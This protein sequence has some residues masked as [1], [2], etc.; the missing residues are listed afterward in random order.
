[1]NDNISININFV[2]LWTGHK[3][4]EGHWSLCKMAFCACTAFIFV[5]WGYFK[6]G[7]VH[8]YVLYNFLYPHINKQQKL[9]LELHVCYNYLTIFQRLL[10]H[11][12][13]PYQLLQFK[14]D[15][16]LRQIKCRLRIS[17]SFIVFQCFV[18]CK[19]ATWH[20]SISV[21]EIF[22]CE[23]TSWVYHEKC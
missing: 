19:S 4:L 21:N 5:T 15:G 1:V 20:E 6:W 7:S 23:C 9:L 2:L 3:Q 13:V 18:Q 10:S 22:L 16:N 8:K 12:S 14:L 17:F 11:S